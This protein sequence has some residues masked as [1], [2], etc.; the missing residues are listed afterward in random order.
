M[1]LSQEPRFQVRSDTLVLATHNYVTGLVQLISS[2]DTHLVP[3]V[4]NYSGG[5]FSLCETNFGYE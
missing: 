2:T 5:N 1:S 4:K 3:A